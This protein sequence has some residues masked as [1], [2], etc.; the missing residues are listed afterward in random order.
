MSTN[1]KHDRLSFRDVE[2]LRLECG[3]TVTSEAI[4]KSCRQ[5][6]QQDANQFRRRRPLPG[7]T[8]YRDE[9]FLTIKGE[10]HYL[11]RAAKKFFG[12]LLKGLIYVPRVIV[13]DKL[14]SCGNY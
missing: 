14:K 7:D 10:R 8:R 4:R 3:V 12:K 11:W 13:I 6:D 5:F 2:E 1:G 9:I